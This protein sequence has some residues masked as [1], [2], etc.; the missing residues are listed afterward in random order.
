MDFT[1]T[2]TNSHYDTD[3]ITVARTALYGTLGHRH[4]P[5]GATENTYYGA[6]GASGSTAI[7]NTLVSAQPAHQVNSHLTNYDTDGDNLI[8]IST[9]A[10]LNAIRYDADGNGAVSAGDR[11]NYTTAF[12]AAAPGMGCAGAGYELFANLDFDTD[13]DGDVDSSDDYSTWAPF[14]HYLA[15]FQGNHHTIAAV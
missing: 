11:T 8:E 12:P 15:V 3:G 13:G 7:P 2:V 4:T 9:L 1:C 5:T 14:G 6:N 10:Q